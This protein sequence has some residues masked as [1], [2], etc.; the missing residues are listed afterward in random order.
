MASVEQL[1]GP[2][3]GGGLGAGLGYATAAWRRDLALPPPGFALSAGM[4]ALAASV[5]ANGAEAICLIA[6]LSVL[7]LSDLKLRL[8]PN[9]LTYGLVL[10]GTAFALIG[11]RDPLLAVIGA[12]VAAG[13]LWSVRALWLRAK[14]QEALGLGDVKMLAGVGAFLGPF[15]LPEVVFW[16]AI[17]GIA[18]ALA[19]MAK[20][21]KNPEIPF[22]AAMALS[23]WL[24][25]TCG[26][27]LFAA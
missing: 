5:F 10:I 27:I 18:L 15:A 26:P 11:P 12:G 24:Y 20:G 25:L 16:A 14:G 6:A 3:A 22:G 1:I 8:L 23:A 7:A 17:S 13:I 9:E 2:L 21:D 19:A 4:V